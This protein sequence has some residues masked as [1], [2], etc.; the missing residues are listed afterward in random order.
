MDEIIYFLAFVLSFS[1][2]YYVRQFALK[3]NIID[4]PN[5]RSSHS[6]PTPRGGGL[7][8]VLS[9]YFALISFFLTDS[10]EI[11]IFYGLLGLSSIAII[12]FI[13]D[14]NHV[15]ARYRLLIHFSAAAWICYWLGII[16]WGDNDNWMIVSFLWSMTLL[17]LVW[18]LNLYNFMDGIDGIATVEAMTVIFSVILLIYSD[19]NSV[20]TELM[21]ALFLALSGFIIWNWPPAKI[22]MGDVGSAFLG[23]LI[24]AFSLITANNGSLEFS[25]WLIL[26][27]VFITDATYTLLVRLFRGEKVYEAHR[28]HAYQILSR[29]YGHKI[30]TLGVLMINLFW[31]LPLAWLGHVVHSI[32]IPCLLLAYIPL[33]LF[34]WKNRA[35][36]HV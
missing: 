27:A 4:T 3:N 24:A 7:A 32:L 17:Y 35:G 31:L 1:L 18:L 29:Q 28:S 22:F 9:F 26:L 12:G 5:E 11:T 23:L 15:P 19:N 6:I 2:T 33:I 36:C 8:I 20:N 34:A 14:H 16:P 25:I 30:V 21:I 10:I 13:D